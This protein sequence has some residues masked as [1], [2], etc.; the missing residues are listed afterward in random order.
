VCSPGSGWRHDCEV[1]DNFVPGERGGE[2][3]L[4]GQMLLLKPT[5]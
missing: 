4:P 5:I 2:G 1:L 3:S